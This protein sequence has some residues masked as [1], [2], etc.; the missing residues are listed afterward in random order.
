MLIGVS[1]IDSRP[2]RYCCDCAGRGADVLLRIEYQ[3]RTQA[4]AAGLEFVYSR[5]WLP[6]LDGTGAKIRR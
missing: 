5:R 4:G 6:C 2:I 1:E 3:A